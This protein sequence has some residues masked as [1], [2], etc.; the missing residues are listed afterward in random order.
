LAVV[1]LSTQAGLGVV[2]PG[3]EAD[4]SLE[5]SNT[6]PGDGPIKAPA[7]DRFADILGLP[8][9]PI[10]LL[11]IG[12]MPEDAADRYEP[13]IAQGLAHVT[14]F[15]PNPREFARLSGR[16]GPYRYLPI[17]L[18][19]GGT[20]T[21]HLTRYPGCSSLLEPDP[22]MIDLFETIGCADGARNFEVVSIERIPTTR[23]DDLKPDIRGDLLK[24]DVQG[25]ELMILR[26][27]RRLLTGTLVLETEA[28]F[29]PLYRDQ[30]LFGDLQCFLREQGFLLHKFVDF[31]GRPFRPVRP[32]NPFA[33]VSQ[34]MWADAIFVRD[35]TRLAAYSDEDLIRAAA[36]LH[37]IYQSYDLVGLLVREFDRRR[38]TALWDR[39]AAWLAGCELPCAAVTLDCSLKRS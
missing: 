18:G 11:D 39:Y 36:I 28:E 3:D 4:A 8:I 9:P 34:A 27:G 5:P 2:L 22:N 12:A 33:P 1:A 13:L 7:S 37:L 17:A 25:A 10:A 19:D 31:G 16:H 32:K 6:G 20:A 35:F 14:G 26:N 23:L 24:I 21:F 15:E 30:P 38:Q 29:V